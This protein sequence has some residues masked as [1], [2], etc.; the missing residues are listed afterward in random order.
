[1][2][3]VNVEEEEGGSFDFFTFFEWEMSLVLVELESESLL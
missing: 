2:G 1:V 3:R